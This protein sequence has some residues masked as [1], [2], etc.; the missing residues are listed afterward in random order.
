MGGPTMGWSNTGSYYS[1]LTPEQMK[2]RQYMTD[3]YLAMQQM[4]MNQMMWHQYWM[5][6][7]QP[8]PPAPTK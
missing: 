2:Q 7:P 6:G 3:Q 4:M 5:M 1:K 8:Q